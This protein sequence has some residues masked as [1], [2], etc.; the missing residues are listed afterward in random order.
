MIKG[1]KAS[2]TSTSHLQFVNAD[3]GPS[4]AMFNLSTFDCLLPIF[5]ISSFLFIYTFILII[6]FVDTA[7][8]LL[9]FLFYPFVVVIF[10]T[11]F[12]LRLALSL[13]VFF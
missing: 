8:V 3:Y 5:S 1:F 13:F 4:Y 6:R 9:G 12:F 7:H 11:I 10:F 2:Q